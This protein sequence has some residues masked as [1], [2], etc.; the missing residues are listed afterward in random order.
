MKSYTQKVTRDRK[1]IGSYQGPGV[2][3]QGMTANGDGV[4][5]WGDKMF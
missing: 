3:D 2:R 5:F 1:Q 4:S